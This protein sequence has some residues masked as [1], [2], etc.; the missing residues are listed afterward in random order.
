MAWS[1]WINPGTYQPVSGGGG[2][3]PS[4]YGGWLTSAAARFEDDPIYS[5]ARMADV[6]NL[7]VAGSNTI[8]VAPY[9]WR[10]SAN[11]RADAEGLADLPDGVYNASCGQQRQII[12]VRPGEDMV[13]GIIDEWFTGYM[14]A[15]GWIAGTHYDTPPAGAGYKTFAWLP[16]PDVAA[17]QHAGGKLGLGVWAGS[18]ESNELDGYYGITLQIRDWQKAFSSLPDVAAQVPDGSNFAS[19][20]AAEQGNW[21]GYENTG[22][23]LFSWP[24]FWPALASG[25]LGAGGHWSNDDVVHDVD[26]LDLADSHGR[27]Q[28]SFTSDL[29][30]AGLPAAPPGAPVTSGDPMT[31]AY[32]SQS[33]DVR[34][35]ARAYPLMTLPPVKFWVTDPLLLRWLH[36]MSPSVWAWLLQDAWLTVRLSMTQSYY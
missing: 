35:I 12:Q 34:V 17:V 13:D 7:A 25:D 6:W 19:L 24:G 5:G 10:F 2:I 15:N 36:H 27:L 16:D 26:L 1:P 4:W 23:V 32:R 11:A 21:P 29:F 18:V 33:I 28:L 20:T 30:A 9:T 14:Q 22:D 8:H 31:A 3:F